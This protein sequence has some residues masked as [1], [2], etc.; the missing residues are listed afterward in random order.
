MFEKAIAESSKKLKNAQAEGLLDSFA[1]IGGFAVSYWAK[2]RATSD[3][4][5]VIFSQ[6]LE[7]LSE[8]LNAELRMG[9]LNDPLE[10]IINFSLRSIPVQLIQCYPAWNEFVFEA[11]SYKKINNSNVPFVDWKSLVLL[12]LYAGSALDL[13]DAKLIL[14]STK[15]SKADKGLLLQRAKKLR[16]DKKLMRV[17]PIESS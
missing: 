10:G 7:E 17:L 11:L 6:S 3:I 9:D 8:H 16:L 1:L 13:E 15:L 4:D 5:Y 14:E 12:K 2:P